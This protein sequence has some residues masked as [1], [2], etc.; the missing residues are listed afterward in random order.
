VVGVA[1][2]GQYVYLESTNGNT[3]DNADLQS[4]SLILTSPLC[5][6]FWYNMYGQDIDTL[7]VIAKVREQ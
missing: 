5:M 2:A 6:H 3:G 4:P 7:S 1:V